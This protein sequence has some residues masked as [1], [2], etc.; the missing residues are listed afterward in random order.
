MAKRILALCLSVI[1]AASALSACSKS[2]DPSEEKSS[3]E[4]SDSV[5][6]SNGSESSTEAEEVPD[7][8]LTVKGK[9]VDTDNLVMFTIDEYDV[10]FDEFRYNY[11][12]FLSTYG[13][14][15]GV[16][17]EEMSKLSDDEK[18][19]R[20]SKFKENLINFIKGTYAYMKYAEDNNI[21]LTEDEIKE[22]EEEIKNLKK[23]QGD[24][25]EDYLKS[26]YMTEDYLLK[27][28]KQSKLANKV[29][30]N[31]EL[32]D[33]EFLKICDNDLYQVR[34]I[35]IPY[36]YD[37]TPSDD[38]LSQMGIIDFSALSNDKKMQH[39]INAYLNLS[40]DKKKE[41]KEKSESHAKDI[42]KR[43]KDGED[44][45]E[46]L[47]QYGFD[48][49]MNTFSQGYV[50]ADF[51][52][53]YGKEFVNTLK[54]LKVGE[55]SDP[56]EFSSGYQILKRVELD[57]DYIKENLKSD[58]DDETSFKEEY[59]SEKEY[60]T[61]QDVMNEMTYEETKIIKNLE[62]GDLT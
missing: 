25:F 37:L 56:F 38:Y 54:D 15:Y 29:K 3:L 7:P 44:F 41:Q 19:K 51:Y 58:T 10:T 18:S 24:S 26:G 27:L 20:F 39:L 5:S 33:D 43:A 55:V 21:E 62:Y 13:S 42:A 6:E 1:L 14:S 28:I 17:Y 61:L 49:G 35:L 9:K 50:V 52:S 23:E 4:S 59:Q 12:Y 46:L 40:D 16:T 30:K 45:E 32:T 47:K 34:T 60:K 11:Y 8:S 2:N 48:G 36:G 31:F 22:C 57:K 53:L